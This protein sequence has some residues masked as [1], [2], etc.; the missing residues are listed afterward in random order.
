[1]LIICTNDGLQP[2]KVQFGP[3]SVSPDEENVYVGPAV[4]IL[5]F[6]FLRLISQREAQQLTDAFVLHHFFRLMIARVHWCETRPPSFN[7]VCTSEQV[8]G[9]VKASAGDITDGIGAAD[10]FVAC[11]LQP[12]QCIVA[13]NP[14]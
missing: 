10:V 11:F 13:E 3:F 14:V 8:V 7:L 9:S 2:V 1:M 12:F 5:D 4:L 6:Q